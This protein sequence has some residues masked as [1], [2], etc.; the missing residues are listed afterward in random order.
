M[1]DIDSLDCLCL[2]SSLYNKIEKDISNLYIQLNIGKYPI[3]P[4]DIATAL[5]YELI[6]F[7]KMNSEAK[8]MLISKDVDGISYYNP[9]K[10]KYVIYYRPNAKKE[11]LRFTIAHEIGHIRM[12]HKCESELARRVANYYA[13]YLL[14]PTPW[15]AHADC[16]D[17][18]DV[19][20]KFFVSE[21]CA[22]ICFNRYENWHNYSFIKSYEKALMAL[23]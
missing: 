3:N 19:V 9:V 6:T 8:K 10:E 21:Q 18:T 20:N 15:I 5:G 16:D 22:I 7:S 17:Y 14:A 2:P 12:G 4:M 13:A 1:K 23:L 11:R